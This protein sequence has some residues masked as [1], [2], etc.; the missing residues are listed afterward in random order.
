MI[1]PMYMTQFTINGYKVKLILKENLLIT[2]NF[3][4]DDIILKLI[5]LWITY[6]EFFDD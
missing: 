6:P 2:V 5:A 4:F 1:F 3:P